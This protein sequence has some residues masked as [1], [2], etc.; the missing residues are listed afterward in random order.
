MEKIAAGVRKFRTEVFPQKRTQYRAL[1]K[2]QAPH[3]M[4]IACADS[5]ITSQVLAGIEPGEIFVERNPGG[6][7][8]VH[9]FERVGISASIEYAVDVLKVENV[10]VCGHSDCGAVKGLLKPS[11]AHEHPAV[12]R[13][14]EYGA[15]AVRRVAG[16]LG[17]APGLKDIPRI[18][19]VNVQVQIEHLRTHPCIA[20]RLGEGTLRLLGWVYDFATGEIRAGNLETGH[21]V[22]WP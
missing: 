8:P 12:G 2:T 15:P 1:A 18:T 13:W 10:I 17:R 11:L 20:R 5:R 16:E 14:L 22:L 7:V 3:T 21:F 19:E 6:L 9:S 4:L